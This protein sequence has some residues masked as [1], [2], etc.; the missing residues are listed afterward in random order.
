MLA[1]P[2]RTR[3]AAQ[4]EQGPIFNGWISSTAPMNAET[5][6]G[7]GFDSITLDLQHGL[8][9]YQG[10]L[11]VLP[12]IPRSVPALARV[13]WLNPASIQKT[14]DAGV[15]GIICP[16]ISNIE[17]AKEFVAMASYPPAGYRSFGP[18]R[19]SPM[20]GGDYAD[21]ANDWVVKIIMLE[22]QGALD[23]LERILDLDGIDGVYVGPADLSL[24]IGDRPQFDRRDDK[25]MGIL[26]RVA[27]ECNARGLFAGIHTKS[28]VYAHHIGTVGFNFV[29]VA[30]DLGLLRDGA[31]AMLKTAREGGNIDSVK[32]GANDAY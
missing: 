10:A 11:T 20:W 25:F 4:S 1:N 12:S 26:E 9:D 30:N 3:L 27:K 31:A 28:P 15:V 19:A 2:L 18:T 22:M 14:L 21:H 29:T 17:E 23:D 5:M 24:A 16:M 13:P 7:S 8:I 32:Q 6:V